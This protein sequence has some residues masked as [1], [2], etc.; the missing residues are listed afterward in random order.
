MDAHCRDEGSIRRSLRELFPIPPL[1]CRSRAPA[2]PGTPPSQRL[3]DIAEVTIRSCA[4]FVTRDLSGLAG[5][6]LGGQV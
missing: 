1:K 2:W 6:R 3:C 4:V 5:A